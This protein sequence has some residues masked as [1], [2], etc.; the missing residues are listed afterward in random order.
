MIDKL[1]SELA[2]AQKK[3]DSSVQEICR[4]ESRLKTHQF[5]YIGENEVLKSEACIFY[6]L[7]V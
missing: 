5:D 2:E 4:L 3:Y 7:S 6:H 1:E